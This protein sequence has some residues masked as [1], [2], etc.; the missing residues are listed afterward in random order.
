MP[1]PAAIEIVPPSRAAASAV[2]VPGSKSVTNRALILA[3]RA[4]GEVTLRGALWSEDTQVMAECLGALGFQL[5]I[6]P[7]PAEPANRVIRLRGQGGAIP[8]AGT[9]EKPLPLFVGN[10]GTAARFLAAFIC[11]GRGSYRLDGVPRMRERPQAALF[12]ALRALGY[13]VETPN[14]RLPA[15]IHGAGPR[16]GS[17]VASIEE[18]SQFASAL[19]LSASAGGWTV[20]VEGENEEE[21]PYVAMT[22]RLIDAFPFGGGGHVIEP[23]ASSGSYF[24][25]A[26]WLLRRGAAGEPGSRAM[27]RDWPEGGTQIDAR[28]PALLR[29]WPESISRRDD[30]GDS[31]MTAIA[32]APLADGPKRFTDLGRLRVQECE[33]VLALK[34]ELGKCGA[35]V[36]EEGDTLRV[37]PS[38][39]RGARIATY[40]DH[41]MAMCFAMLGLAVPGMVIE[42]PDCVRKTFPNFFQK[43]AAPQPDGLGAGIL[44]AATGLPVPWKDLAAE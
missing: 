29:R 37:T 13:E 8:R 22:L 33:R 34:T 18:S 35:A 31:V 15:V 5:D 40:N 14:D 10:A 12:Q 2:T 6:Q 16:P 17:C 44:D 24:W 38:P 26:D 23:D 28:F 42:H 39:L 9:R 30:L 4:M 41:R 43:L 25:G 11:L 36:A 20:K 32:L 1:L 7:D 27:V 21:S 3:A 19:H